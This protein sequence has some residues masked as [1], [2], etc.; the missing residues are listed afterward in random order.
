MRI[1]Q[2]FIPIFNEKVQRLVRNLDPMVDKPL[3]DITPL[4]HTCTLEMVCGK[5]MLITTGIRG[6]VYLVN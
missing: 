1:L 2:S 5:F 6:I 4:M 3:F